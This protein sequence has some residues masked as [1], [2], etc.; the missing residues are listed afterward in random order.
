MLKKK[1]ISLYKLGESID[2]KIKI[3]VFTHLKL[4]FLTNLD[5]K[6]QVQVHTLEIQ[7]PN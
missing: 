2:G 7:E 4:I 6:L 3:M 5:A 1:S